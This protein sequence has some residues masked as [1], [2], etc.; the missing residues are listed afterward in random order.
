MRGLAPMVWVAIGLLGLGGSVGCTAKKDDTGRLTIQFP[1]QTSSAAAKSSHSK[2]SSVGSPDTSIFSVSSSS[3]IEKSL[4]VQAQS[5]SEPNWNSATPANLSEI[6]CYAVFVGGSSPKLSNNACQNAQNTEIMRFGQLVGTFAAGSTATLEVPAGKSM[7][8]YVAGFKLVSGQ[9]EKFAVSSEGHPSLTWSQYSMPFL[10]GQRTLDISPGENNVEITANSALDDTTKINSCNFLSAPGSTGLIQVSSPTLMPNVAFGTFSDTSYTVTNLSGMYTLSGFAASSTGAEFSVQSTT[11]GSSLAPQ[12]SCSVVVRYTPSTVGTSSGQLNLSATANSVS[13]S[14]TRSLSTNSVVGSVTVGALYT[15]KPAWTD[16]VQAASTY[17]SP[18][19]CGGLMESGAT[20]CVHA[21]EFRRA[22]VA[23]GL[24]S[25]AGVT[26]TD[27][28][29]AFTW[30]CDDTSMAPTV[31]LRTSKMNV[32]SPLRELIDFSGS[33]QWKNNSITVIKGGV[34]VA[35]SSPAVW[36]SN[37]VMALPTTGGTLTSTN[38]I[39]ATATNINLTGLNQGYNIAASNVSV[40][41]ATG[42]SINLV[43][44]ATANCNAVSGTTSAPTVVS[45]FCMGNRN[46]TWIEADVNVASLT[47]GTLIHAVDSSFLRVTLSKFRVG[48]T[49]NTWMASDWRGVRNSILAGTTFMGTS[50]GSYL[51]GSSF[52]VLYKSNWDGIHSTGS[53]GLSLAG[54]GGPTNFNRVSEVRISRFE[55]GIKLGGTHPVMNNAITNFNINNVEHQGISQH[56]NAS[57]NLVYRGVISAVDDGDGI[58]VS[59]GTGLKVSHVTVIGAYFSGASILSPSSGTQLHQLLVA[60][61][62]WGIDVGFDDETTDLRLSQFAGVA[63]SINPIWGGDSVSLTSQ[64]THLVNDTNAC[65]WNGATNCNAQ[66]GNFA[67]YTAIENDFVGNTNDST[68]TTTNAATNGATGLSYDDSMDFINFENL[69][70]ALLT[71]AS[72]FTTDSSLTWIFNGGT[73]GIYD[74]NLKS[75]AGKVRNYSGDATS[76]NGTFTVGAACPAAASGDLSGMDNSSMLYLLNAA[77]ILDDGFGNDDGFCHANEHCL[78][79]PNFG[80]YQGHGDYSGRTC[81]YSAG[82]GPAGITIYGYPNNGY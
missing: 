70:R 80:Y 3:P 62:E 21:G 26:A 51:K 25:C 45:V 66:G 77:E 1:G 36:W 20:S 22:D 4:S 48:V 14:A 24:G 13:Q 82:A 10:I 54:P 39:Y 65:D 52:N 76:P 33:P 68:N 73:G 37:V 81:V 50:K 64:G 63:T 69:T 53:I 32:T 61:A 43:A 38:G 8:F 55:S 28:L 44:G 23:L 9:C 15:G 5:L 67:A 17:A 2:S 40:V 72:D 12:A 75:T 79:S 31:I 59:D 42:A 58:T 18:T 29:N 27:A 6:G 7:R 19:N 16:Y 78:Y 74:W 71:F 11:C 56:Q 35:Q 34:T 60:N 46:Y 41:T 30:V 57:S 47:S 49:S